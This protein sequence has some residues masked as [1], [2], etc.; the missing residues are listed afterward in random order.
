MPTTCIELRRHAMRAPSGVHLVQAGVDLA[1]R[2]GA[3]IGEIAHVVTSP[4]PRAFETAIAMGYAV[5]EV[6]DHLALLPEKVNAKVAWDE[7]FAEWV[8]A[9][10]ASRVVETYLSRQRAWFTTIAEALPDGTQAL[11]ISHGGVVEA[12]V[13]ACLAHGAE[14]IVA[15]WGDA[16]RYTE[17][18]RITYDR[19]RGTFIDAQILRVPDAPPDY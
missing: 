1:R 17:G 12:S 18:V 7:G 15:E 3:T 9:A 4:V 19:T 8:R 11:M 10:T 16:I 6:S 13:I 2:V 14:A 5:D